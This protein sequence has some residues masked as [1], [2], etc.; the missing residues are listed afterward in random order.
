MKLARYIIGLVGGLTFGM[1]FAP[2]KGKDLRKELLEKSSRSGTETLEALGS[3]F[4][5]AGKDALGELKSISEN[6]QVSAFLSLSKDKMKAF[7][8]TAEDKGIDIASALQEK[9]N[10]I[11]AFVKGKADSDEMS[12]PQKKPATKKSG[13]KVKKTTSQPK[14]KS[15]KSVKVVKTRTKKTK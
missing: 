1:L 9:L 13:E 2:K 3:A 12:M 11:S 4:K 7:L 6:E 15:V 10:Y 5:G 8:E 14:R